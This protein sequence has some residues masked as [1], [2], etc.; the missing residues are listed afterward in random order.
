MRSLL[1]CWL[2]SAASLYAGLT[3]P[4]TTKHVQVAVDAQVLDVDFPFTNQSDKPVEISRVEPSCTCMSVQLQGGK[5]RYEPGESG[6]I[7]AT[8]DMKN[9]VGDVERLTH[10]WLRG[11]PEGN[12][13]V[14]LT[15]KFQIP[16]WV[17]A[18]PRTLRWEVGE[19]AAA[20]SIKIEMSGDEPIHLQKVVTSPT[21]PFK[22]EVKTIKDGKEYELVVTPN[23]T[24]SQGIAV[25]RLETDCKVETQRVKQVFS[26]VMKAAAA[27]APKAP[28][29][30]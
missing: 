1:I 3:F 7:R 2:A 4:E 27:G 11:D 23:S 25:F 15:V 29:K 24:A 26:T 5:Q 8:F 12:P 10:L 30:P 21:S 18:E 17:K 22:H 19:T 6:L 16:E 14:K 9:Q 20:K 13:S 28:A